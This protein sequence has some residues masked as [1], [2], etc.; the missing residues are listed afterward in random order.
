M[1]VDWALWPCSIEW[2]AG[3]Q[4]TEKSGWPTGASVAHAEAGP[5]QLEAGPLGITT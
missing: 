5:K 3:A 4:E 2:L 1:Q